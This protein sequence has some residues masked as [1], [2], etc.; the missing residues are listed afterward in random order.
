MQ[1]GLK[2]TPHCLWGNWKACSDKLRNNVDPLCFEWLMLWPADKSAVWQ[3]I[4]QSHCQTCCEPITSLEWAIQ[5]HIGAFGLFLQ[6]F[7]GLL[8][9]P[10][11]PF[12]VSSLK[13]PV[14]AHWMNWWPT[15]LKASPRIQGSNRKGFLLLW[16]YHLFKCECKLKGL[17]MCDLFQALWSCQLHK[18]SLYWMRGEEQRCSEKSM[19]LW[20]FTAFL[21]Q[22]CICLL[23]W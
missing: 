8:C 9:V 18:T 17:L 5:L 10:F 4:W 14:A 13:L 22:H 23:M 6:N 20:A 16:F 21:S 19:C 3:L 15:Q 2:K 11:H 1:L 12:N 7:Y